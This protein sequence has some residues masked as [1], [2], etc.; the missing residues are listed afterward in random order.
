MNL[1]RIWSDLSIVMSVQP[2]NFIPEGENGGN[3]N[4]GGNGGG[5][6][7]GGG[8]APPAWGYNPHWHQQAAP[9]QQQ[10]SIILITC[11]FLNTSS[12]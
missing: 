7:Y 2:V 6:P 5:D 12:N 4:G 1:V 10:V 11:R 3:G 8:G 9:Q